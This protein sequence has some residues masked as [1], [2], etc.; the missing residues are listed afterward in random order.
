MPETLM[1]APERFVVARDALL[2]ITA[3]ST[4]GE[5]MSETVADDGVVT[6]LFASTMAGYPGWHWTVSV[7]ELP[8]EEPT[9]LE[10]ELLPGDG[11]LLAPD[12]VP[13]SERLED[14][15]EAQAAAAA[16]AGDDELDDAD[17]DSD[18]EGDDEDEDDDHEDDDDL[19]DDPDDGIDFEDLGAEE[20]TALEGEL[21]D[22]NG[23][24][25]ADELDV[26]AVG[27]EQADEPEGEAD[28]A[29]PEP[30]DVAALDERHQ[31]DQ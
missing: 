22:V 23:L 11:A 28:D 2:E 6:M 3:E 12:W 26:P 9:V 8:G 14:Y 15:K 29:G 21:P 25:E 30:P 5:L 10:A 17:D 18:D 20:R 24:D 16:S 1:A 31:E 7:A 27:V 19:G 4:V 13:W